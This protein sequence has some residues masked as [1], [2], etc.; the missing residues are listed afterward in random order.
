MTAPASPRENLARPVTDRWSPQQAHLIAKLRAVVVL[1]GS[2]RPTRLR[3]AAGRFVLELPVDA[4]RT[5]LDC[6][7]EQVAALS[8]YF[9]LER[10]PVRVMIDH[11]TPP[12]RR[13][14]WPG[15][16]EMRIERDP[17]EFRGTGG[18]LRDL[19]ADYGDDELVLVA[20]SP[21]LLLEPLSEIVDALASAEGDVRLLAE[22]DGTPGGLMLIRC[23]VLRALPAVGFVDLKEQGLPTIAR[24]HRVRVARRDGPSGAPVRTLGTYLDALR[25]YHRRLRGLP[26]EHGAL[27]EDW[28][29]AFSII[30]R[31]THVD[32]SAIIHDSVILEGALV[33]SSAVL[34][35]SVVS[36]GGHV[37]AGE[38]IVDRLVTPPDP[39]LLQR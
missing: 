3:R 20:N 21:Q 38:S 28:Q 1:A 39:D 34:V 36:P 35:R 15:P 24:E 17:L 4:E 12:T 26:I 18:L 9:G 2:M 30:E 7:H 23:G 8:E 37:P 11:A 6:W 14:E 22:P 25:Q 10:L 16:I 29:P 32:P 5:V 33:E 19:T 31:G 13:R 27:H